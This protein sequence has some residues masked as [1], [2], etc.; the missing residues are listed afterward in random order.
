MVFRSVPTAVTSNSES[1]MESIEGSTCD[2]LPPSRMMIGA[3]GKECRTW[4]V[5]VS[6]AGNVILYFASEGG[7]NLAKVL[8]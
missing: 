2:M 3:A 6:L 7:K 4:G 8:L 1:K 5:V